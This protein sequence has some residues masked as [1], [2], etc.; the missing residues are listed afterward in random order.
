MP[1]FPFGPIRPN[2]RAG[3]PLTARVLVPA[4]RRSLAVPGS[5]AAAARVIGRRGIVPARATPDARI[6]RRVRSLAF[7]FSLIAPCPFW[8][9]AP[10]R[11]RPETC[12][13]FN[14]MLVGDCCFLGVVAGDMLVVLPRVAA[15]RVDLAGA[16]HGC[17]NGNSGQAAART[18]KHSSTWLLF[19]CCWH[20]TNSYME[21]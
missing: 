1:G 3:L 15:R 18:A 4:V 21:M 6:R 8:H 17:D 16:L 14:V 11:L 19:Q 20:A 12:H 5:G 13:Q 7:S 9:L 10:F 2:T